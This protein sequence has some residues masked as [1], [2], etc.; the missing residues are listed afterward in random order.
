MSPFLTDMKGEVPNPS[1]IVLLSAAAMG[2][3]TAAPL[4]PTPP[5]RSKGPSSRID[6]AESVVRQ[7]GVVCSTQ[8]KV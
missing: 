2:N 4:S 7:C 3:P 8:L 1:R 6:P 5:S